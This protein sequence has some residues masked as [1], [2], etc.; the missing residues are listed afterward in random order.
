V[1]KVRKH[2]GNPGK[3]KVPDQPQ[4]PPRVAVCNPRNDQ[5]DAY[6][7]GNIQQ[8]KDCQ[9]ISVLNEIITVVTEHDF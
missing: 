9:A 7:T 4:V 2:E 6:G 1:G 8:N 5:S 3:E